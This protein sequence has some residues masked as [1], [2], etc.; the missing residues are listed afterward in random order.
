MPSMTLILIIIAE[1]GDN[2]REELMGKYPK[3]WEIIPI[4]VMYAAHSVKRRGT[5]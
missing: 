3:K 5:R 4:N 2:I 1:N